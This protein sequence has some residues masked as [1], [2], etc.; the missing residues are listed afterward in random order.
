M[1]LTTNK[2]LQQMDL[3]S[4][5]ELTTNNSQI[6]FVKGTQSWQKHC[7]YVKN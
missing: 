6:T 5:L 7:K 3:I 2:I 1:E 4:Q